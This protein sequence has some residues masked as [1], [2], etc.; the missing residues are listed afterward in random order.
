MKNTT[1]L[2]KSITCFF[3]L[4]TSVFYTPVMACIDYH[5]GPYS[6]VVYDGS[7]QHIEITVHN[8]HLFGGSSG[9]FCTCAFSSYTDIFSEVYYVAFVDSGTGLPVPGFDSWNAD[10]LATTAWSGLIPGDSWEGFLS[11]VNY[12]GLQAGVA[13]NLIIRANLPPG[14]TVSFIDSALSSSYLGTDKA[15]PITH[16]PMNAHFSVSGYGNLTYSEVDSSYFTGIS[17][18]I[19]IPI[20]LF[21][22]PV[23]DELNIQTNGE[24]ITSISV[25]NSTG[26][27]QRTEIKHNLRSVT[28]DTRDLSPGIYW[29]AIETVNGPTNQKFLI[30]R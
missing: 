19:F 2:K 25:F 16:A 30:A 8:L 5:P 1:L 7:Y 14:Y 13:V 18:L 3:I 15:D 20:R 23:S 28:L 12:A 24:I 29:I 17:N 21:P 11:A 26:K 10:A 27:I 22:N 9:D 4:F 6:T